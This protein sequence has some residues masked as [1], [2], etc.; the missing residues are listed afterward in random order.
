MKAQAPNP[1][2]ALCS[3]LRSPMERQFVKLWDGV[4][5]WNSDPPSDCCHADVGVGVGEHVGWPVCVGVSVCV[6]KGK[7]EGAV[8]VWSVSIAILAWH[9]HIQTLSSPPIC[10]QNHRSKPRS[11]LVK[12]PNRKKNLR[13]HYLPNPKTPYYKEEK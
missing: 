6:C 11:Q 12:K 2:R 9:P 5:R 8:G 3:A 4:I 13:Q 7:E 10:T 1:Q